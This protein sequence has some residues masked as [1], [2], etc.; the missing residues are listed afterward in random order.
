MKKRRPKVMKDKVI[1]FHYTLKTS[2]GELRE[3]SHGGDPLTYL[4]GRGHIVR[5]LERALNGK[6]VNRT[7]HVEVPPEEGYGIRDPRLVL[8]VPKATS[9]L[10]A[11]LSIGSNVDVTPPTGEGQTFPARVIEINDETITLDAN[12]PLAG[13]T[14][15]FDIELIGVR[16][17]TKEELKH[18]HAHGSGGCGH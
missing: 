9:G 6:E 7:M 8:S 10:P 15:F 5:G 2:S 12:H 16:S 13:E 17:A 18:G 11:D 14:L 4:H 1:T 3:S